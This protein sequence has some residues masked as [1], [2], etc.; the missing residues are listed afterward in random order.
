MESWEQLVAALGDATPRLRLRPGANES[1]L[2]AAEAE[3]GVALPPAYRAWLRIADGQERGGLAL[4]PHCAWFAPLEEVVAFWRDER[5]HERLVVAMYEREPACA[6]GL[7]KGRNEVLAAIGGNTWLV[8]GSELS[9]YFARLAHLLRRGEIQPAE[10]YDDAE[11]LGRPG[12]E[13]AVNL[14]RAS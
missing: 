4:F 1:Q 3:L 5:P 11:V 9:S 2:V 7:A 13:T 10:F 14:I 12:G 6:L 8:L